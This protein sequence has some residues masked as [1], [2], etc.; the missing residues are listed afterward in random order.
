MNNC[1]LIGRLTRD[2]ELKHTANDIAVANFTIA[3]DRKFKKQGEERE[4]DFIPIVVWDKLAEFCF[5]YLSKGTRIGVT[6]E[7][8]TRSYDAADG[9]KRY[10]TEIVASGVDFADS[11]PSGN[12]GKNQETS[13]QDEDFN[14]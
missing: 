8:R 2:I 11:K 1:A 10:V 9:T 6:G 12:G 4:T 14:L 5:K 13:S 7:I 3:V